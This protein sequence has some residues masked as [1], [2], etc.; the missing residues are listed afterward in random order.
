[1][2]FGGGYFNETEVVL[3]IIPFSINRVS[4]TT[5]EPWMYIRPTL[6]LCEL[7]PPISPAQYTS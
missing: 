6:L 3:R 7:G 4:K 5:L 2:H 1:M